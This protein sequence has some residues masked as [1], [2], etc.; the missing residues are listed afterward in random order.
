MS[1]PN[2]NP[3]LPWG[4]MGEQVKPGSLKTISKDKLASF[5]TGQQK[6]SRFQKAREDREIKK[7]QE[8]EETAKIYEGFVNSFSDND[9]SKTFLKSGGDLYKLDSSNKSSSSISTTKPYNKPKNSEMDRLFNE[10]KVVIN[11]SDII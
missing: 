2:I 5:A 6:K 8:E 3:I 11:F 7:K 10:M 4:V 1:E 9:K